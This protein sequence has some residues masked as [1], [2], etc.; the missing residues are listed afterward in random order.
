MELARPI[1]LLL[2]LLLPLYGYL[3][4]RVLRAAATPYAPLQVAGHG[5]FRSWLLRLQLPFEIVLLAI[6]VLTLAGPQRSDEIEL[7]S[8]EG[9]DVALALDISASMQAA[10][11]PPNRLE[12]LKGLAV[13]FVRR[14]G[15]DRIAVYAF[16]KHIFSQ[17][18][19][20]T[21]HGALS[22]LIEGLA[23]TT[24]DHAASGGTALGDAL[25]AATDGLLRARIP[26]RDQVIVLITDGQSNFGADPILGARFA[27]END[28]ALYVIGVGGEDPVEVYVDGKPFIT[29]EDK[30]LETSLDDTQL[31]EIAE[32]VGG[33]YLRAED[34]N[35]LTGIF[36]DLSRLETTPLEVETVEVTKSYAPFAAAGLFLLFAGWLLGD[37]FLLRRPL[38]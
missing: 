31:V 7:I 9:L 4:R 12:A 28:I 29:V 20:T 34:M 36:D 27:A 3:R 14:S 13:D 16:A 37:G 33:R 35:V 6:T 30:I 32:A 24:I 8:E 17:T 2:L 5:G 11:F 25:L 23:F 26:D 21:D 18:P 10:D 19:L 15:S 38:R 22:S 1:L